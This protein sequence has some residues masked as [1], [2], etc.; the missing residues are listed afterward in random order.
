M[1]K[2]F[3]LVAAALT[4]MSA[5]PATA[6]VTVTSGSPSSFQVNFDGNVDRTSVS[7]LTSSILFG[8]LGTSLDG[9]T[10]NFT[11]MLSN[12]SSGS[13]ITGSRVSGFAFNTTPDIDS[14]TVNGVFD[15]AFIG[16]TLPNGVKA[17]DICFNEANKCSGGAG[18]GVTQGNSAG[19]TFALKFDVAPATGS[20][21]FDEFYVRYQS[22]NGTA[23]AKPDDSGTGAGTPALPVPEPATWGMMLLGFGIVGSALRRRRTYVIA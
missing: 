7:G 23:F 6:A 21:S 19:G 18:G 16:G 17:V 2:N 1:G 22:L 5:V 11:Y 4:A 13:G 8:F 9:L 3:Y 15:N 20:L 10:Y 14:A 12:T